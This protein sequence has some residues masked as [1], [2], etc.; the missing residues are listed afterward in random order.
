MGQAG[1]RR[2]TLQPLDPERIVAVLEGKG[3][4]VAD[5]STLVTLPFITKSAALESRGNML[6]LIHDAMRR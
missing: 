6:R 1:G 2:T 3:R 4:S 5:S